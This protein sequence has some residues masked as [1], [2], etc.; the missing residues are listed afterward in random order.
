M[1]KTRFDLRILVVTVALGA[2]GCADDSAPGTE[3]VLDTI[4]ADVSDTGSGGEIAQPDIP[5]TPDA[6]PGETSLA[7]GFEDETEQ[8][9][10]I[11]E[12]LTSVI[13]WKNVDLSFYPYGTTYQSYGSKPANTAYRFRCK[14]VSDE[15]IGAHPNTVTEE[16]VANTTTHLKANK[17]STSK[18]NFWTGIDACFNTGG[19]LAHERDMMELVRHGLPNGPGTGGSDWVWTSDFSQYNAAQVVRWAG[20]DT[21]FDD[22]YST[23]ATHADTNG[24][25]YQYRCAYYP[26]DPDFKAVPKA[27]CA[28]GFDCYHVSKGSGDDKVEVWAD[29]IDRSKVNW[30]TAVMDCMNQGGH[31]ASPRELTELIRTGFPNGSDQWMWTDDHTN[32]G[33]GHPIVMKWNGVQKTWTPVYSSNMTHA[34]AA[35]TT[36]HNYRCVWNNE[37]W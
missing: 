3:Q 7:D 21:T 5:V 30:V 32:A 28:G 23:Y 29:S 1:R 27:K 22:T 36:T 17:S 2:V 4:V 16:Y 13:K 9:D 20:I 8:P 18:V 31:L 34:A 10:A 15:S 37:L 35:T 11:G 14:G 6:G 33:N 24:N 12:D 25:S 19:H 26:I